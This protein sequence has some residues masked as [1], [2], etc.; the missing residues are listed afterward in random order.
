MLEAWEAGRGSGVVTYHGRMVERLHVDS[1]ER[2]L[3]LHEAIAAAGLGLT[4][5]AT[6]RGECVCRQRTVTPSLA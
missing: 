4:D 1:A 6:A 3:A 5:P 2:T